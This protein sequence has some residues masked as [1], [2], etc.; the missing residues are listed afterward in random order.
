MIRMRIAVG[1]PLRRLASERERFRITDVVA[2]GSKARK[3]FG[4]SG[5]LGHDGPVVQNCSSPA[6]VRA[7]AGP[8]RQIGQTYGGVL[9]VW[10]GYN[11]MDG[12]IRGRRPPP[13]AN[14]ADRNDRQQSQGDFQHCVSF[15]VSKIKE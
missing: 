2:V 8:L 6:T 10:F 11:G 15:F 13:K 12:A 7:K 4:A 14:A 3:G 1:M 9:V 5:G